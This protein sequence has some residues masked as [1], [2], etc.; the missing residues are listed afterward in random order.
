M[1]NANALDRTSVAHASQEEATQ[2]IAAPHLSVIL[3]TYNRCNLVLSALASLRRQTL[4]YDQFEV[5]VV[6]NGSTDGTLGVVQAYVNA[7][8]FQG[9]KSEDA[10]KVRCLSETQI[11]L[12]FARNTGLLAATG[13]IAVFL[14]DDTMAAP[15]FL[16]QLQRA[17]VE[18]AADAIGGRVE[19]RWEA[20]RPHWLSDDMLDLLGYFS[21]TSTRVPLQE[22]MAFSSNNFSVRISALLTIGSFSS[23]LS[24]RPHMPTCLEIE[25]LCRRLRKA[26]YTLWYEPEAIVNHR[27]SAARLQRPYFV[28]RAYWQGRSEALA[29][30][31]DMLAQKETIQQGF[32]SLLP[33][34]LQELRDI[35]HIALLQRPLL[36]FAGASTNERILAAMAQARGWGHFQQRLRFLEH[37]PIE[38]K[39][40]AIL[41]VCSTE[42]DASVTLFTKA[43]LAQN[44]NYTTSRN[45]ILLPWLW[46]HR[47]YDGQSIAI[48][49]IHSPGGLC[50]TPQ[51]R[52]RFLF[53]V[54]LAR[55]LGIRIMCTDTGGWWQNVRS[56]RYQ[57]RR[58][59][60]RHLLQQSDLVLS[61]TR[62]LQQLYPDKKLRRRVRSL[63][64]PGYRGFYP[65]ALPRLQAQQQLGL[66]LDDG[67]VYLCFAH[68]H[69][70]RE[71]LHLLQAF[72]E[73]E[74][75]QAK[76]QHKNL[77][78]LMLVGTPK[79][80]KQATHLLKQAALN[81]TLHLFLEDV[82]IEQ[83]PLYLGAAHAVVIPHF[84]IANAG[85][86]ETALLALSYER[87][88]IAPDLPRFHGMLPPHMSTLYEPGS[89][90]SLTQALQKVQA[91]DYH[92]K[93]RES[94]ALDA[95]SGWSAHA[96]RVVELYKRVLHSM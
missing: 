60:E 75:M 21:P 65:P 49:H 36:L 94:L 78:Q 91:R 56:L 8:P 5:I 77:G 92:L 55:Y 72:T 11:G 79:D 66:S 73:I 69:T 6:D 89:R 64:H 33:I 42:T 61:S 68:L 22:P 80:K 74:T 18:T 48:L 7:G 63:P 4:S 67:P 90:T 30:Y 83:F 85:V 93:E 29:H 45:D 76:K 32:S 81:A 43:L 82:S 62:Q 84:A 46:Q 3:C 20:A 1:D 58:A 16:E 12:A 25:D 52:Q 15:T 38:V 24:K 50:A 51:Q 87:F 95:E 37:A 53:L 27:I 9:K 86:L 14:D 70:E 35:A 17:Y 41:F 59:F 28:G 31:A 26:D 13:E 47:A 10:W 39:V 23:F 19:L 71:L 88:V 54:V 57:P 34:L 44:V 96:R 40:P 2:K